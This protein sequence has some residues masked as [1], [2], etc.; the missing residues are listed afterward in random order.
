MMLHLVE[1]PLELA[2][3]HRWAGGREMPGR[4][5]DEGL[6]LHHL[7]TE[8]FGPRA[9]QPFRLMVAPRARRATLYAYCR[10]SA[11]ALR[12]QAALTIAPAETEAIALHRL[13]SLPRPT[14]RWRDGM[15]LGFDLK[16]RPV[17]RLLK[18]LDAGRE[19]F[20]KGAELDAFL[21]ETLRHDAARSREAVYLD[22][23][24]DRFGEAAQIER[25]ASRLAQFQR[26]RVIR[27][28][29]STEG[30]EAVIHGTLTV[31]DRVRF[32]EMLARGVGRHRAYGY[33][34]VLLR[35]PGRSG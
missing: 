25:P 26:T 22:W 24:A 31:T 3:L 16:F 20:A 4:G 29:R 32:A 19:T 13:R 15:R 30:P 8:V 1:L 34:M 23:L 10:Q 11:D 18:P 28:G 9:L 2:A 21:A 27:G 17:V 7:L 5:R 6:V 12:A 33:G 14:E 35:P